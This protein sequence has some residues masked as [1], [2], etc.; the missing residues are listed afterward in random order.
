MCLR[1]VGMDRKEPRT[2][3]AAATVVGG[4]G[5]ELVDSRSGLGMEDSGRREHRTSN[6][7]RRQSN[8]RIA[9]V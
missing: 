8:L 6:S 5:S 7:A 4:G 9:A 2:S 1:A 3:K